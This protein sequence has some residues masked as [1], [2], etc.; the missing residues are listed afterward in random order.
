MKVCSRRSLGFVAAML[1]GAAYASVLAQGPQSNTTPASPT[2]S[3]QAANPATTTPIAEVLNLLDA[4]VSKDVIKVYIE[5]SPVAYYP[6]SAEIIALKKHGLP[7]DLTTALLNRSA[8]LR[9][10]ASQAEAKAA[11]PQV[12]GVPGTPSPTR[13]SPPARLDT[14]SYDYF[15][16]Y[17]LYPRT[18][19]YAN[20]RLSY[21]DGSYGFYAPYFSGP[22]CPAG[23]ARPYRFG[24]P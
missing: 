8:Q 10:L 2:A 7:D 24:V 3:N 18:L 21:Y 9:A 15:Q 17:Y 11:P 23:F 6:S 22:Y 16:H 1:V 19:A 12:A 13:R 20:S 4:G 5:S 14:E